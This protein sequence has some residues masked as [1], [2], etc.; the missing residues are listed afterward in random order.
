[1][2]SSPTSDD[3]LPAWK[4]F[5]SQQ[6][7]TVPVKPIIH[8]VAFGRLSPSANQS[9]FPKIT[10]L[11]KKARIRKRRQMITEG[12]KKVREALIITFAKFNNPIEETL[13][14]SV[15]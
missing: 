2:T 15:C 9:R 7:P 10:E 4:D 3:F 13:H 12:K 14:Q 8:E 11:E 1:M 5:Q 6:A